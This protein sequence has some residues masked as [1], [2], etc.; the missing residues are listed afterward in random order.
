MAACMIRKICRESKPNVAALGVG[1]EV[2]QTAKCAIG[3]LRDGV[4]TN[5]NSCHT[6]FARIDLFEDNPQGYNCP[7][8]V[9][10]DVNCDDLHSLDKKQD[11]YG[12]F[13]GV[14]RPF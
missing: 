8:G 12:P 4:G 13:F 11:L 2:V 9:P 3:I 6:A 7:E 1:N 14:E 5:Q 10:C